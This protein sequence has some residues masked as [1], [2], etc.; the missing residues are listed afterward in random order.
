[1]LVVIGI[2]SVLI[3]ILLPVVSRVRQHANT[4]KCASTLRQ[5]ATA[6]QMYA[7]ANGALSVPGRLPRYNGPASTVRP[8][9]R[10][11]I[12]PAL[13]RAAGRA[14]QALRDEEAD[15]DR[16]RQLDREGRFLPLSR[17]LRLDQQPQLSV[18]LQLPVPRQ[19]ALQTGR[20]YI[21]YPVKS[22][23]IK[24]A[25]T[26]MATDCMGTAA[27]KPRLKRNG[28]YVDGTKDIFAWG[29]KAWSLDP[30]RLT[31]ASDYADP[32]QARAGESVRARSRPTAQGQRR[33][34][35][36]TR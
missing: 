3:G 28:Y 35:R 6:W 10:R 24:A 23:R 26:V 33:V 8:G 29:N 19:R 15:Q 4:V 17:R 18:R 9:R 34:L 27:G 30:P 5:F 12:P 7:A 20:K 32:Q 31:A 21:N 11:R 1:M 14:D 13:V 22:G 25:A 36:R 2:I 16:G